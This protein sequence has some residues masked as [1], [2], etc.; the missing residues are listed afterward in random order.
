M[1]LCAAVV[2]AAICARLA[3]LTTDAYGRLD[4]S[5]GLLTDEGFYTHNARN[6]VALGTPRTDDFNN[7]LLSPLLHAVQVSALRVGGISVVPVRLVSVLCSL[8]TLLLM[9]DTLRRLFGRRTAWTFVGIYGLDHSM[10]LFHRMALMDTPASFGAALGFRLFIEGVHRNSRVFHFLSSA[11]VM[12]VV[13]NRSLCLYLLPIPLLAA[14]FPTK[15]MMSSLLMASTAGVLCVVGSWWLLWAGPNA[16]ELRHMTTYYRTRQVQPKSAAGAVRN[17][18]HAVLG[19]HRGLAPYLFRHTGV[20]FSIALLAL[21]VVLQRRR[22]PE[23]GGDASEQITHCAAAY[24]GLWLLMGWSLLAVINYSPARY[25]VSTYPAMAALASVAVWRWERISAWWNSHRTA[26]AATAGFL[27]FHTVEAVVH[28]GGV[29]PLSVTW[30]LLTV[31]PI[32]AAAVCYRACLLHKVRPAH[33][34]TVWSILN[35]WWLIGW[36]RTLDDSQ[37]RTSLWLKRNTPP[38]AV[39]IGD[40]APGLNMEAGRTA[41]SVIP[42]LCNDTNTLQRWKGRPRYIVILDGRWK[43]AWWLRHYPDVIRAENRVLLTRVL[44]WDVG[45]YRVPDDR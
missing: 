39:L 34:L 6:T 21:P 30:T 14:C 3:W 25:Y 13:L 29:V 44:R 37:F 9:W 4:W 32:T 43:E 38:N 15:K 40:V 1:F 36:W 33:L 26:A 12:A 35:G 28:R 19:D 31:L 27:A 42:G 16:A 11:V 17:I 23:M 41:V 10:L 5:A 24:L 20:V 22:N 18:Q 8:L 7:M 45:I 2:I